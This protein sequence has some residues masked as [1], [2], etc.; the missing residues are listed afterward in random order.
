MAGGFGREFI[1]AFRALQLPVSPE[2]EPRAIEYFGQGLEGI[3]GSPEDW[4]IWMGI[5]FSSWQEGQGI[6]PGFEALVRGSIRCGGPF[7]D[8]LADTFFEMH[9]TLRGKAHGMTH[10]GATA[11]MSHAHLA[12]SLALRERMTAARISRILWA[13]GR[14]RC[15]WQAV[16]CLL[17]VTRS[18]PSLEVHMVQKQYE[19]DV[20]Q[21]ELRLADADEGTCA[22]ILGQ[23]A[24]NLGFQGD[25]GL[26][27]RALASGDDT[28]SPYLQILH[29]QC[30]IAEFF[31]HDL[32]V[33]YEFAP[34]G[35]AANWLFDRYGDFAGAGNPVL[36]NAKAVNRL[37]DDWAATRKDKEIRQATALCK[38]IEGLDGMG[39]AQRRE[40]AAWLRLWLVRQIRLSRDQVTRIPEHVA[41][42]AI[43]SVLARVAEGETRT[44]GIIEQRAIDALTALLYPATDGWKP[45]GHGDS[46]NATNV[47]RHKLGDCDF[48]KFE[49]RSVVAFEVHAGRLTETYFQGHRRTLV[50]SLRLRRA[51]WDE[52]SEAKD[53]NVEITFLAHS[54][55][56]SFSQDDD[57]IDGQR[58]RFYFVTFEEF[59]EG[60]RARGFAGDEIA[61][62]FRQH[63]HTKLN[64]RNTPDRVRRD[65]LALMRPR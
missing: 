12:V 41:I 21:E 62:A 57:D 45:R 59:L 50:R 64:Q 20:A 1:E 24:L 3:L 60:F 58:I 46:V 7:G 32:A 37:S 48:Q 14:T 61:E 55:D 19:E 56:Q 27:L 8:R 29:F 39:F 40:L 4:P 16:K 28:H 42:E 18:A 35:T 2:E 36:N 5:Q 11:F 17:D 52:V 10:E 49:E 44:V 65:Y 25:L 51:E 34:R 54:F 15:S 38:I 6:D 23:A 26:F 30:T 9:D 33:L 43:E 31:D 53:W 47:S 63:V 13:S 22:A